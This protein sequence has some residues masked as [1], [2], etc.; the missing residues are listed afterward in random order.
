[1]C[2]VWMIRS[3]QWGELKQYLID[4]Y[5]SGIRNLYDLAMFPL[6]FTNE[7]TEDSEMREAYIRRWR[8]ITGLDIKEPV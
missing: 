8:E 3:R 2:T 1:M 4:R 7:M 6:A 5:A